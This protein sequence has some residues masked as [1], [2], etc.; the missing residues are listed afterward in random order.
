[1]L[2]FVW[3]AFVEDGAMITYLLLL[4]LVLLPSAE[5]TRRTSSNTTILGYQRQ[6]TAWEDFDTS[7]FALTRTIGLLS[8]FESVL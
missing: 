7:P 4:L 6:S 3:D 2:S 5:G 8:W 1:M